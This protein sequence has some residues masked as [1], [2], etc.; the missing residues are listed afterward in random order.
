MPDAAGGG[1]PSQFYQQIM[2]YQEAPKKVPP[3]TNTQEKRETRQSALVRY[4]KLVVF[5]VAEIDFDSEKRKQQFFWEHLAD[6]TEEE[7]QELQHKINGIASSLITHPEAADE[8][9]QLRHFATDTINRKMKK[10]KRHVK[11]LQ[12]RIFDRLGEMERVTINGHEEHHAAAIEYAGKQLKLADF[13]TT[14]FHDII[15]SYDILIK[16]GEVIRTHKEDAGITFVRTYL[17]E[18]L[19]TRL[20]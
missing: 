7:L 14:Y 15:T 1:A 16:E 5:R 12:K 17:I 20:L 19:V 2:N 13:A 11:R 9:E 18:R 10:S 8:F 3:Y 6:L 4:L